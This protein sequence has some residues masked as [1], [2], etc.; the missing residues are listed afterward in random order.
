MA[1]IEQLERTTPSRHGVLIEEPTTNLLSFSMVVLTSK[2]Y[3][4]A[5]GLRVEGS[6]PKTG[7]VL[8]TSMHTSTMD[9]PAMTY[10]GILSGRMIRA[11][12]RKSLLDLSFQESA[13][14][15]ERTGKKGHFDPMKLAPIA[16][17]LAFALSGVGAIPINRDSA[18]RSISEGKEFIRYC[19]EV[20]ASGQ[21]VGMFMQET[22]VKEGDLRDIK[23]GIIMLANDNKEVPIVV[24]SITSHGKGSKLI[25]ISDDQPTYEKLKARNGGK[26][27]ART[28]SALIGDIAAEL[29]PGPIRDKWYK[30]DRPQLLKQA[31]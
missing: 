12:T 7:P 27:N 15:L 4:H 25:R 23:P 28:G 30:E 10:A 2:L 31:A 14:V 24:A 8:L 19:S 21:I 5:T 20:L 11:V 26:L 16:R 9:I 18:Q 6:I 1:A 22:R 3:A 17:V 13:A 29:V